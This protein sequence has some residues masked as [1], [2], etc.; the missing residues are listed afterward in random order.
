[1]SW[2]GI[3]GMGAAAIMV[4]LVIW[5]GIHESRVIRRVVANALRGPAAAVG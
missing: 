5:Q 2:L 4:V 3:A 1:M